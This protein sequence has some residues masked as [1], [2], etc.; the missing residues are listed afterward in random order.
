[1]VYGTSGKETRI[2]CATGLF[3]GYPAPGK[4]GFEIRNSNVLEKMKRGDKDIPTNLRDLI[5]GRTIQGEYAF[6]TNMRRSRVLKEGEIW[7]NPVGGTGGYGDVLER[8]PVMVMEDLKNEIISDWVACNIFKVSYDVTTLQ[9]DYQKTEVMRQRERDDRIRKRKPYKEFEN[10]WM[11]KTPAERIRK[12]YGSW[13]D[14]K[15][16]REP[17]R[18]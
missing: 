16:L 13:P 11:K 10:E 4:F 12:Y 17:L 3:G 8:D 18:I 6:E 9:V 15:K 2:H 7:T 5:T 1:M 14:A